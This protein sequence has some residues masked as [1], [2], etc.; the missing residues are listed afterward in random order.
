MPA[1]PRSCFVVITL[2]H[3]LWGT[4]SQY[5]LVRNHR[6]SSV[7]ANRV[8]IGLRLKFASLNSSAST[9]M[10]SRLHRS[11]RRGPFMPPA[12]DRVTVGSDTPS[13]AAATLVGMI[14]LGLHLPFTSIQ[15]T[16]RHFPGD[17]RR[18]AHRWRRLVTSVMPFNRH[19]MPYEEVVLHRTGDYVTS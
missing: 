13:G 19:N 1:M 7:A 2:K 8:S 5:G 6:C 4:R 9:S 12:A 3:I 10:S 15:G 16:V 18:R 11:C 17:L 14:S